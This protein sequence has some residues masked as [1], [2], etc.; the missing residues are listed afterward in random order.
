MAGG[1]DHLAAG[2]DPQPPPS[3]VTRPLAGGRPRPVLLDREHERAA[4]G[5][6]LDAVRDGF[7]GTLVLQGGPGAGKTV[8]LEY[9]IEAASDLHV[10]SVAGVESEISMEFAALHQLLVPFMPLLDG[11]PPPQRHAL[12][13]AFGLEAG[14]PTDRFAVGLAA[15]TML[16]RGAEERPLLCAIDDAQWLDAESAQVLGF[17]ARRLYA[18]RVGM[19]IAVGE[20]DVQSE[21]EQLPAVLVGPLPA[22]EAAELLRNAVRGPLG[23]Q[24]VGRILGD[25]QRNPL[26][27]V[28]LGAEFTPDQL[29]AQASQPEPLPL[30]GRLEERFLRQVRGLPSD[31]RVFVG[32]AAADVSGERA[33]LW[34][35]AELA[36]TDPDAAALVAESAG[37]LE[38]RGAA[39]RFRHPLI[40]SAVYHGATD[41]ERRRAHLAL[42]EA[43]SSGIDQGGRAWHRAAAA[44]APDEDVAAELERAAEL[45]RGR[46]GY[47]AQAVLLRRSVELTP[48]DHRR[49]ERQVA[50]AE[51]ELASGRPDMARDLIDEAMPWLTNDAQRGEAK[52][53][54][55][56][57]LFFQG[58]ATEAAS[59]LAAASRALEPDDR[60]ARDTTLEA[61]RAAIW[62]GPAETRKTAQAARSSAR[63]TGSPPTVSDFLLQGYDARFT[64]GYPEAITPFRAAITAL[65]ADDLD[66]AT[67]LKWFGLGAAAAG[68][69]WDDQA[70][71]EMSERWVR[72]ARTLGGLADLP[73][74][75]AFLAISDWLGGRFIDAS[76]H[77]AEMR[78]LI[79]ASHSLPILGID[80]RSE[81]LLLAYRGH[82]T[83]ARAAGVTQIQQSSAR[84]QGGP[85]DIGRYVVAVADLCARD[86][87]AAV[88]A[89]LPVIEDDPA[90][91]SEGAMPELVEAATR[92]GNRE[93]AARAFETLSE[94]ALA[95]GT[96]WALGLR[97]RC[98]ALIDDGEHAEDAYVESISQ[99]R[100]CRATVD[101]A[102]THLLYGEW[103]RRA[104][105]RRDARHQLR[106]AHDMFTA[107]GADGFAE[108]AATELRATGERA[109]A[110]AP[111][112]TFDL[113]PREARVAELAAEGSSNNDIA[114]QLFI[115]PSTVEYHLAKVYRKLNVTSRSQLARHLPA[116]R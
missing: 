42:A 24:V 97:A 35:A 2:Q 60:A 8:L 53:Q 12:G 30:G 3:L 29:A 15:L 25:T 6:V 38:F 92:A 70:V 106:A 67:G 88:A 94:R 43:S 40:R 108:Q 7:S 103:L 80:S 107:M 76:A 84:G 44:T 102:R 114:A 81:G 63:L 13:V 65:L 66:P 112:T 54:S 27:L 115:S 1:G 28:E 113:T 41:A 9:A 105:R 109:R 62:A 100:Q 74:A 82:T 101:L 75:L 111:Q 16:S 32:L 91:T 10:A 61:L 71:L 48:D 19:I 83:E 87:D 31:A 89:A 77:W 11:L 39:V 95:A 64:V 21:F 68:S 56:E 72:T 99:L 52:R 46:G 47:S 22:A 4:I 51:A 69:L 59:A 55:G 73:V 57:I 50:L 78:E 33:L 58:K 14:P 23:D 79:A 36:G 104:K 17:V 26:A 5:R 37:L 18:D 85:A 34:R 116:Q 98:Q 49:A 86:Y 110:R 90:F 96:P 93:T 20:P 45:A